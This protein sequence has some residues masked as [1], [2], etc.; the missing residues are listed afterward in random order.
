MK[1]KTFA[2]VIDTLNGTI[3]NHGLTQVLIIL[4]ELYEVRREKNLKP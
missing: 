1:I 2:L 4:S 3:S